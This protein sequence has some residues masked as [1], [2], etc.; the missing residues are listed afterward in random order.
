MDDLEWLKKRTEETD[1]D[2]LKSLLEDA[3]AFVLL[4]TN[5]TYIPGRLVTLPR[6]IALIDYNRL[7]TEGESARTEGGCS[8]TFSDLPESIQRQIRSARIARCGGHAFEKEQ[9]DSS[10]SSSAGDNPG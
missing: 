3:E 6:K 8:Y 5:R 4:E 10:L 9:N 1:E 7:G 2:I